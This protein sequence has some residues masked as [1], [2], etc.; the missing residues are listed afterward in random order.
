M[1]KHV[2]C[3]VRARNKNKKKTNN[4]LIEG[5]KGKKACIFKVTF[6]LIQVSLITIWRG[7]YIKIPSIM[8]S[9][10]AQF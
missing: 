6:V 5:I 2:I 8:S 7:F 9:I 1:L 10:K 3:V 4:K